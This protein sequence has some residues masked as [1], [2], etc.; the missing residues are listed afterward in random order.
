MEEDKKHEGTTKSSDNVDN[1]AHYDKSGE[2]TREDFRDEK[3]S[4]N[5][6]FAEKNR[7]GRHR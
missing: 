6:W 3:D 5:D 7:S 2:P 1:N 4:I